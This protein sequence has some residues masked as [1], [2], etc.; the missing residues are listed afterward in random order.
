MERVIRSAKINGISLI[1]SGREDDNTST[2]MG[3]YLPDEEVVEEIASTELEIKDLEKQPAS[4]VNATKINELENELKSARAEAARW[5]NL[6]QQAETKANKSIQKLKGFEEELEEFRKQVEHNAYETGLQKAEEENESKISGVLIKLNHLVEGLTEAREEYLNN[7]EETVIEIVLL[8]LGKILGAELATPKGVAASVRKVLRQVAK[9]E[10]LIIHVSLSDFK[11]LE[12]HQD[13]LFLGIATRIP[14]LVPDERVDIGGC[15]IESSSGSI[16]GR[17][18][19]Q[20]QMLTET[21][22]KAR[23]ARI[24]RA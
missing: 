12:P 14:Q 10:N 17:L 19:V 16:D 23:A 2:N 7:Q 18:E 4:E 13:D 8:A 1:P 24:R 15:I 20:L 6:A 21:L 5:E 9:K 11:M 3:A 22:L